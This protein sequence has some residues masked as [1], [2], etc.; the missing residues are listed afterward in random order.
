[1]FN[2]HEK[3]VKRKRSSLFFLAVIDKIKFYNNDK[4]HS[5]LRHLMILMHVQRRHDIQHNDTHQNGTQQID[6]QYSENLA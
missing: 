1:M 4:W 5:A 6:S 3:I 2:Y